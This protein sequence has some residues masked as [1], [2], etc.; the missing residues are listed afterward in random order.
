MAGRQGQIRMS[1]DG[2]DFTQ[3][4]QGLP[5]FQGVAPPATTGTYTLTN[6][7]TVR[8]GDTDTMTAAQIA[9]CLGT[10]IADLRALGL[11]N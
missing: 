2:I 3:P 9:D 1:A 10:L 6:V 11:V 5:G 7:A 4:C 8:S